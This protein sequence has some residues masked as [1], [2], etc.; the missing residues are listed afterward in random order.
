M[1]RYQNPTYDSGNP[2]SR[3]FQNL[4]TAIYGD[5]AAVEDAALAASREATTIKTYEDINRGLRA[6]QALAQLGEQVKAMFNVQPGQQLTTDQIMA[7]YP[8]V[9]Q[10]LVMSGYTPSNFGDI[11][12]QASAFSG[13]EATARAGFNATGTAAPTDFAATPQAAEAI[14]LQEPVTVGKDQRVFMPNAVY[15]ENQRIIPGS[16]ADAVAPLPQSGPTG[17][18]QSQGTSTP[19]AAPQTQSEAAMRAA[20]AAAPPEIRNAIIAAANAEG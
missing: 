6:D 12:N 13:N 2:W 17:G 18:A 19:A 15:P 8:G 10:Q 1:A 9:A 11:L 5:P 4:G 16:M 7:A 14:R 3:G 20:F